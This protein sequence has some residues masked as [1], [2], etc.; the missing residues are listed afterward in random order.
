M[1]TTGE[2]SSK[3]LQVDATGWAAIT[4]IATAAL[5][6]AAI[7][8]A[9][10]GVR[11]I[12]STLETWRDES[13][14]YVIVEFTSTLASEHLIDFVVRNT[15]RTPAFDVSI[16]WDPRPQEANPRPNR[17]FSNARMFREPIAMLAPGRE[18][19]LYFDSHVDRNGRHDL[20]NL[21]AVTLKYRDRWGKW[22]TEAYPLEVNSREGGRFIG[23]KTLHDLAKS[24][25][26]IANTVTRS[27]LFGGQI[28]VITESRQ[29]ATAR[30][31][32]LY[33]DVARQD[34]LDPVKRVI[35]AKRRR[36]SLS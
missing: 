18:H 28:E 4:A 22:H 24:I 11:Q 34:G 26:A 21:Y 20:A 1:T 29:Q 35:P 19:R 36:S 16:S 12:R 8:T 33:N 2:A 15:G 32:A 23:V 14:A 25:E 27:N 5:F 7:I 6:L 13:R 17:E 9:A 31:V 30:E 3:F 10:I